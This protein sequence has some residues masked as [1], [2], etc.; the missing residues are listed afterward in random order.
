MDTFSGRKEELNELNAFLM[1]LNQIEYI[2]VLCLHNCP[3][4]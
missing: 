3:Q 4:K 1:P 2:G